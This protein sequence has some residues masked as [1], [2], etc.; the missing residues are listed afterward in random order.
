MKIVEYTNSNN[1]IVEFQDEY[2]FRKKTTYSNFKAGRVKNPYDKTVFGIGYL[3]SGT[4]K[5]WKNVR[6]SR[7][8]Y[9]NWVA[10]LQRCY[11]DMGEKYL[12]YYG[13]VTVCDEWLNFQN[14]AE[15]YE[16]HYYK[17]P[18]ERL[19]IDK[20]IKSKESKIYSPETCILIPQSINEV[21]KENNRDSKNADLPATIKRCDNGYKVAFR[22][23]NLG[24]Y[25]TIEECL[26]VY[27]EK[28]LKYIKEL[29]N[30]YGDLLP[31]DIKDIILQWK[32]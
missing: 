4:H 10:M 7:D 19:H 28:K 32:P 30:S 27:N 11:V 15:W 2:K 8:T 29:V 22:Y 23:E 1:I 5:S 26:C 16:N 21:I 31:N 9:L 14:F 24:K 12:S 18:N 6:G 20:D 17:I 13:I 25:N 3:G